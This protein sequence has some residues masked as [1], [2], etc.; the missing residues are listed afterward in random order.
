MGRKDRDRTRAFEIRV[1]KRTERIK[2]I[3]ELGSYYNSRGR[4]NTFKYSM[5]EEIN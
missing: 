2:W 1:W 3:G 4:Q 5:K